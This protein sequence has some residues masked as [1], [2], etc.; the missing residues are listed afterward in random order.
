MAD[1]VNYRDEKRIEE[2]RSE[3]REWQIFN[4]RDGDRGMSFAPDCHWGM[5]PK[6]IRSMNDRVLAQRM[7][8][9]SDCH[10]PNESKN[11]PFDEW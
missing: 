9:A 8:H 7:S 11:D 6:K 1:K 3:I 2:E 5:N 10:S 4:D